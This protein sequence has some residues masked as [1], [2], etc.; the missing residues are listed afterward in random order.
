MKKAKLLS[1]VL[2]AAI[3]SSVAM[4]GCAQSGGKS[5]GGSDSYPADTDTKNVKM[6]VSVTGGKDAAD[7][8]AFQS[9]L[10]KAVGLNVTLE[11]PA[12]NYDDVLME[13]LKSG[14][15]YD[16][17]YCSQ[18]Q[19]ATFVAQKAVRDITSEVKKSK[20][21]SDTSNVP[22]SEW[23]AIK[24][25]G[26]I[27][28]GFN[29]REVE[30][31][32]NVNSVLL[33]K[34]GVDVNSIEPTLDGYYQ[35]FTKL[36]AYNDSTGKVSGFYP[37]NACIST[38]Y[39]L[40]P[41]FASIGLKGGIVM[42]NGKRTVPWSTDKAATVWQWL[43]KLYKEGLMDKDSLTNATKDLR[44]KFNTGLTGVD[45]D[46]AAWTGLYNS[47]AGAKYPDSFKAV[48]LPGT[49]TPSGSYMLTKGEASLFTIPKNAQ[50]GAGAMKVLEYLATPEGGM[51]LSL[52]SEGYD[53]TK[54]GSTYTLTDVGKKHAMDHG[55]PLP[56]SLKY[57]NPIGN[58]PG[59]D[60][61][62]SYLKYS[63]IE[64]PTV[65]TSQYQSIVGKYAS[66]II[67]GD[68]SVNVGLTYMRNELQRQQVTN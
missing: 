65:Y 43:S 13:K 60:Q 52:G 40:Q 24:I 33:G 9:A 20:T 25:D 51:L 56:I 1:A 16:L 45:V 57:T 36:K 59:V 21:L 18:T 29:K 14:E 2:A 58:N 6:L 17:V 34:A 7:M 38:V 22:Q 63:S 54:S 49:K 32:V 28:A 23:D 46:W 11:K 48:P 8:Q 42:Q 62:L 39:D 64:T 37:Y 55:A 67:K 61:A 47:N 19:L 12:S 31:V 3:I 30:R 68:V 10:S 27:Y 26:K 4:T 5:S 15:K 35:V 66:M 50:N 41:W 53:Y 44:N